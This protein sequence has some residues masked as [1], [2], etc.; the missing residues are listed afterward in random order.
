MT[1]DSS[2][3]ISDV[4]TLQDHHPDTVQQPTTRLID[5]ANS[6]LHKVMSLNWDILQKFIDFMN[7]KNI[8]WHIDTI[9]QDNIKILTIRQHVIEEKGEIA[10]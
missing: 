2:T 1:I 6:F 7:M 9:T 5:I 10:T 3:T 8:L 4:P